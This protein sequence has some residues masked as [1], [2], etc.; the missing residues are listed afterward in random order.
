MLYSVIRRFAP[1]ICLGALLCWPFLLFGAKR[2]FD[3]NTNNILDWLP[4]S[5]DETQRLAW[6]VR[7]FG[8]DEILVASW[9]GCTL[10]DD[11]LDRL[12]VRLTEPVQ[13]PQA[14]AATTY[15][16]HVFTGR[17]VYRDL[18]E[19]PLNLT[20]QQALERMRGWL[21]GSDGK[22]TCAVAL[23]SSDGIADRRGALEA[24]YQVASE[25]GLPRESI[26]LGGP[27]ADSVAINRASQQWAR[28]LTILAACVCMLVAWWCLKV[29]RLVACVFIA[30]VFAWGV[31]LTVVYCSG[32]NM[33]AVLYMMPGLVFVLGVSGAVHLTNYYRSA[34]NSHGAESATFWAISHGW[35]PC[36]LACTTTTIG[37]G[38]LMLSQIKPIAKFGTFSAIGVL[39]VMITL[40]TL[41]P[42]VVQWWASWRTTEFE[43]KLRSESEVRQ[44]TWWNSCFR[45]ST[46]YPTL[47]LGCCGI[48][49]ALCVVGVSRIRGSAKLEDL[50]TERSQ[51]IR[52]YAWLQD[53]IG[54]LVPVE[55]V[56]QFAPSDPAQV[57]RRAQIVE[58]LRRQIDAL[59]HTGGTTAATTFLV[60]LPKG[61]GVRQI[62][63][64]RVITGQ[65]QE[66][67]DQLI[68]L[69]YLFDDEA[70]ELWRISTRVSTLGGVDYGEFLGQL[71][72]T[73]AGL[74][75]SEQRQKPI[76]V[77][78]NVSG[79]VPLIYMAQQQLL[80]DLIKSF[81]VAFLLI[82]VVLA[83]V[84]ASPSA[85]FLSMFPNVFPAV[86]VFGC[87][88][89]ADSSIDIGAMMTASAALG[90]AVDDTLHFL[91]WFRRGS[92]QAA[93][94]S[95]AI[96]YA[97]QHCATPML[98]TSL[99]C[100]LGL[101][102]FVFSPF[103][104]TA[105]FGWL[106]AIML[107][108]AVVADILLLPAMLASPLGNFFVRRKS[109]L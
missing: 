75:E 105:R 49:I 78:A 86:I 18:Q 72:Q 40:L 39:A 4:S 22:T 46:S 37:L 31:S 28:E 58:K 62:V 26:H 92:A 106:M 95:E 11:R 99:I 53:H 20:Q 100:G 81:L 55:I 5:F 9:A 16:R 47:V 15:F 107:A 79:G 10:D 67:R 52:D 61:L 12:A 48:V 29:F 17:Q 108:L 45:L 1:L 19:S 88:G 97:F 57:L 91:V 103:G 6:F 64:R 2:A 93:T 74:L 65:I 24:V 96:R 66:S 36:V 51:L 56:L 23:V 60:D 104:P 54:P 68:Q 101:F 77:E 13:I 41:W 80:R 70:G 85:G 14:E 63:Q 35:L 33:D 44:G 21:L 8:S 32:A 3:S 102:V 30:A 38:S 87:L 50:L 34:V 73:V 69:R 89:W 71:E 109:H 83:F 43:E 94:R 27:T 90:I 76:Q 7:R 84:M 98:Q 42:A 82:A 25:C 59:D